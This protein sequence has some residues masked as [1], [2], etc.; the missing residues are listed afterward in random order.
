MGR[1]SHALDAVAERE[2]DITLDKR[3]LSG[4]LLESVLPTLAAF[5]GFEKTI[6]SATLRPS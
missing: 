3:D 6:H 4:E 5:R 1:T 2:L